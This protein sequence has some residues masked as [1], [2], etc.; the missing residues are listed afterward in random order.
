MAKKKPEP[1]PPEPEKS[2]RAQRSVINLKGTDA[3][4]EWLAGF[5]EKT[6]IPAA[7]IVRLALAM[8]AESSGYVSPPKI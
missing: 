1:A 4:Y 6:H 8:Y 2:A 5:S 7:T 3:Y